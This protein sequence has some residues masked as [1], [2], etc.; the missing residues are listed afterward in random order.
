L[1]VYFSVMSLK[2][3]F[4]SSYFKTEKAQ[5]LVESILKWVIS[6]F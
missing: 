6:C 1:T 2:S 5:N 4:I 3:V